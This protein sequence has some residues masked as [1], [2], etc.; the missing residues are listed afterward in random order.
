MQLAL[1]IIADRPLLVEIDRRLRMRF[2]MPNACLRPDPVTQLVQGM[3][4]GRTHEMVTLQTL[5][6]LCR[7]FWPWERLRD[8]APAE[9]HEIIHPVTFSQPKAIRI[10]AALQSLTAKRGALTLDFLARWAVEDALLW[11][12]GLP[13]VGRKTSAATLNFSGLRMRALVIDTHHLRVLQRL[14]VIDTRADARHAYDRV[15]P[16]L[17]ADWDAE[18]LDIHHQLI[19]QLG[20]TICHAKQPDCARCPL[21]DLCPTAERRLRTPVSA[22]PIY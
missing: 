8:A 13:G 22:R 12:E 9:I 17:P 7:R 2:G 11:L 10:K 16:S 1:P 3:L 21:H 20:Q 18:A 5:R 14:R 15:M 19:K 4:G 6:V